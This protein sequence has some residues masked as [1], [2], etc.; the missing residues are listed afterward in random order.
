MDKHL[1]KQISIYKITKCCITQE[2]EAYKRN[3]LNTT[4]N[5]FKL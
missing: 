3:A 2:A 1:R 5:I 4:K